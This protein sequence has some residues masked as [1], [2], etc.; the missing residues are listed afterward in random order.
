MNTMIRTY[1]LSKSY[2][3]QFA[4]DD[5]SINVKKGEI[6]GFLGRNGAGKT[7]TIRMLLGLVKP[8][9]GKI[10]IF[11]EDFS[12]NRLSILKRIGSTIETPGFYP[13]LTAV[14]NL[15]IN[16]KLIG[17][18]NINAVEDA[19]ETV[20]LLDEKNKIIKNYSLGMKQ[21]L[22]IARAILHSPELLILDE[23]TNGLDPAGI[24]E[25]RR[26]IKALS[27]KRHITIFMSS[28]ILSE[29]QQLAT[30]IGIIHKGK[31]L[32]EIPLED[33]RTRNRKYIEIQVSN[34]GRAV[35]LLEKEM[36]LYDY[37]VHEDNT[38][39]I[40][41]H[42]EEIGKINR[43]FIENGIDVTKLA[44]S[45]DNLEDYFLKLTGGEVIG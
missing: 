19:L 40:Y 38:L 35:T 13:E 33:L 4:V 10:E 14:E 25:V 44:L 5:I 11:G 15:R 20:G 21:R 3:Q 16:T 36:N 17:V 42:L 45:E 34:D 28:H 27:E 8:S 18:H 23:P 1:E 43:L 31:L 22:G 30:T 6:Y 37:E 24:K 2:G 41:S 7:T 39:R 12:N 26:L 9:Q 29:V 32:E